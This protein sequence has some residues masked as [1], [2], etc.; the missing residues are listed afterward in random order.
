MSKL[1]FHHAL[2]Y[3]WPSF[4]LQFLYL[5]LTT[6]FVLNSKF[7]HSLSKWLKVC[8][9][10]TH[11]ARDIAR[12]WICNVLTYP[13][14]VFLEIHALDIRVSHIIQTFS[15]FTL[16]QDPIIYDKI[17]GIP[18]FQNFRTT[19]TIRKL[20]AKYTKEISKNTK[21]IGRYHILEKNI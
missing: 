19:F 2:L 13:V 11:R 16:I 21:E 14:P 1:N 4:Y 10:A 9:C 7:L 17:T 5:W 18:D 20:S 12:L 3:L 6:S 15:K 8:T